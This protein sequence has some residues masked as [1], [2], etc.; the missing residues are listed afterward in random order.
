[1][2]SSSCSKHGELT[3]DSSHLKSDS[4]RRAADVAPTLTSAL[5]EEVTEKCQHASQPAA[6]SWPETQNWSSSLTSSSLQMSA[7]CSAPPSSPDPCVTSVWP[8]RDL[9][10]TLQQSAIRQPPCSSRGSEPET[11]SASKV[12]SSWRV[13]P[14]GAKPEGCRLVHFLLWKWTSLQRFI[15]LNAVDMRGGSD[16]ELHAGRN[17]QRRP[18]TVQMIETLFSPQTSSHSDS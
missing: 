1:M 11:R 9:C 3:A 4:T 5:T 8:L 16:Q 13:V 18:D 12:S 14:Q 15:I 2:R 10:V 7:T 6:P 17:G